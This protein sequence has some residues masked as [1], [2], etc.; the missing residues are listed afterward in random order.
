M[1]TPRPEPDARAGLPT[2]NSIAYGF[3]PE[4]RQVLSLDAESPRTT[5]AYDAEGSVAGVTEPDGRGEVFAYPEGP[6]PGQL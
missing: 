1:S 6:V 2:R 5:T 4:D 3:D